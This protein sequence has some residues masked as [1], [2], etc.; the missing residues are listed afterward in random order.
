MSCLHFCAF[1]R[2]ELDGITAE[3]SLCSAGHSVAP[4]TGAADMLRF[5]GSLFDAV[6]KFVAEAGSTEVLVI[7][8]DVNRPWKPAPLHLYTCIFFYAPSHDVLRHACTSQ[9]NRL[10]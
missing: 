4:A 5:V 3:E 7:D 9:I 10:R 6:C 1:P 2:R 8:G